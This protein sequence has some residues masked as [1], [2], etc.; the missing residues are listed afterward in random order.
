LAILRL[1]SSSNI[2]EKAMSSVKQTVR[3]QQVLDGLAERWAKARLRTAG[4]DSSRANG[5]VALAQLAPRHKTLNLIKRSRSSSTPERSSAPACAR[6]K[7]L[8]ATWSLGLPSDPTFL[9]PEAP[10]GLVLIQW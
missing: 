8:R 5:A 7:S 2:L 9:A 4:L 1:K 3:A 6:I 10:A